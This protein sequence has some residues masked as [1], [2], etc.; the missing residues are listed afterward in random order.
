MS[1]I[2]PDA[3]KRE[4]TAPGR[5]LRLTLLGQMQ[6]ED[7]SG[8]NVLPRSRKTRAL[9]AVLALA[10]P[11]PVLRLRLIGLLWSQR[12]PQQARASLRQALHELQQSLGPHAAALLR[13]DRYSV[14]MSDERVWVDIG[15]VAAATP[16]YPEALELLRPNLLDG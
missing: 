1:G 10:A 15:A 4:A 12:A 6:A 2:Q 16:A 11:K 5:L 14:S 7:A 8:R 3:A 13:A 9:L